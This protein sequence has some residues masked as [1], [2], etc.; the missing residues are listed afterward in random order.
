MYNIYFKGSQRKEL[1]WKLK[2]YADTAEIFNQI[3]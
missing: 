3:K 1:I 2:F